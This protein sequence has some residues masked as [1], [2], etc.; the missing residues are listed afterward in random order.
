MIKKFVPPLLG[1]LLAPIAVS[2][3]ADFFDDSHADLTLLNRYLNQQGR[4][5]AGSNAKAK[6][7]RDW[8]QGFEFNVKSGYTEGA[9]GFGL[10]LQ[11]FYGL[12]LDSGGI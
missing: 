7:Y 3:H 9:V 12:K 8:G 2:A 1:A 5:V 11:A 6:S 10:D 4:D